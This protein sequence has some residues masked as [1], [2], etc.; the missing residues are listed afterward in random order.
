MGRFDRLLIAGSVDPTLTI[1][2]ATRPSTDEKIVWATLRVKHD[3]YI[4]RTEKI[5]GAIK[6]YM[7]NNTL[8][9]FDI[10]NHQ[11]KF[12]FEEGSINLFACEHLKPKGGE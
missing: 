9:D 4:P 2:Y 3:G 10:V 8:T 6:D 5:M 1:P 7:K 11:Y 12:M